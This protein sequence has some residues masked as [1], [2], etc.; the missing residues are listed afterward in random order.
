MER[1]LYTLYTFRSDGR[2]VV[3]DRCARDVCATTAVS[4]SCASERNGA[5]V[6]IVPL[7]I[8]INGTSDDDGVFRGTRT[9]TPRARP[10][11]DHLRNAA[12][13]ATDIRST[14]DGVYDG[15]R[16]TPPGDGRQVTGRRRGKLNEQPFRDAVETRLMNTN[17][18]RGQTHTHHPSPPNRSA[19]R[20]VLLS[21]LLLLL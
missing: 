10:R 7:L 3:F 1:T 15:V 4:E 5:I 13:A 16:E 20:I 11:R 14:R 8:L 9:Q 2:R 17:E 18:Q 19:M 21:L 6:T 12:A